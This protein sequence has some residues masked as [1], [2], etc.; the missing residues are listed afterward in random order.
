MNGET[1]DLGLKLP[2]LNSDRSVPRYDGTDCLKIADSRAAD[3]QLGLSDTIAHSV[4]G[5]LLRGWGDNV[6]NRSPDRGA[7]V[8][9]VLSADES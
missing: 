8:L 7:T 3:G 1:A 4:D 9:Q 6:T 5:S 2:L